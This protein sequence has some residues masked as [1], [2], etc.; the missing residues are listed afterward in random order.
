MSSLG[1][2]A[3]APQKSAAEK[4]PAHAKKIALVGGLKSHGPAQH[5]FPNGIP[6]F[7]K[8][9]E[10]APAFKG[11]EVAAYPNDF[12]SDLSE[13]DG[14]STLLLY[15]DG[16]QTPPPPLLAP[17]RIAAI[18]KLM[19][20]GVGLICLHQASTV[21]TGDTTI[22]LVEWLG[23]KRNGMFDRTTE[24]VTL[25][26]ESSSFPVCRRMTPFTYEDEFYP[27]LIFTKGMKGIVPILRANVPKEK[28]ADHI[29]AWAYERPN[30][31][32]SF[33]FTG[34]HYMAAFDQPQIRKMLLNA[35]C[36]TNGR[37]VPAGGIV[38]P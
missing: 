33:G 23:A 19:D 7:K 4:P 16:V 18:Q 17:G 31:G 30:G 25:K 5:D 2:I 37:T 12:P 3:F 29:L 24:P 35:I 6:L 21:P 32:R 8:L 10:A 11:V 20:R 13:L 15:L 38:V 14:A 26:P 1:A 27:T 36:W 9:I 34:G 28:P 22:P